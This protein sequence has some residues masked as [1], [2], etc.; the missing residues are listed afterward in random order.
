MPDVSSGKEM[1]FVMAVLHPPE[2][3]TDRRSCLG[4]SSMQGTGNRQQ[5]AQRV[6][7]S[8]TTDA[9]RLL[10]IYSCAHSMRWQFV[11]S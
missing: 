8:I 6:Y 11:A 10:G 9:D 4:F 5:Q 1:S 3:Q 7:D 2:Q